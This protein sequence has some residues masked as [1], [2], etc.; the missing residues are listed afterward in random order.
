[1]EKS[2]SFEA[3]SAPSPYPASMKETQQRVALFAD[4]SQPSP[5][6]TGFRFLLVEA[7]QVTVRTN[8]DWRRHFLHLAMRRER[9]I[10]KV[11]MARKLAVRLYWMWRKQM[12]TTSR[13]ESSDRSCDRR[14]A[15]VLT[16]TLLRLRRRGNG[17][18][19]ARP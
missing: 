6:A 15:L 8:P 2:A 9:R 12:G 13:W 16:S 18:P 19:R 1:M 11:A 10:A 5:I 4:V 17:Y 3:R 7:A 14:D